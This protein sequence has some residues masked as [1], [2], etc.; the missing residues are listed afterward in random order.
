[1][2]TT[3]RVFTNEDDAL[4]FWTIAGPIP[5]CRGFAIERKIT[6]SGQTK[7]LRDF[8]P[9]RTGFAGQPLPPD[10]HG[11]GVSRPS[12]EWPFQRFSWID[13]DAN[14]GDTVS[15][16][17]VPI[18]RNAQGALESVEIEATQFSA[19]A[20]LGQATGSKY[21][22]F[23]NRGFVMSQFMAR[24]L[25]EHKLT[26]KQ[27]KAQI[28]R[29]AGADFERRIRT[30]LSGDLRKE[31][32]DLLETAR[33]D[34]T[35]VYGA[36]FELS[37]DEL[38]TAL[39][40]LGKRAHIVLANGSVQKK[41][42]ETSEE[43]RKRDENKTARK[44]L[45]T[46][47]VDVSVKDRF[48]SPGALG[49]NK[50]LVLID[51]QGKPARVWTGST[52]W[53]PTGLCTQ[54]NNGL[55]ITDHA[56]ADIY[57][58]QWK[59]LRAA[60]SAFPDDLMDANSAAHHSGKATVW[61][62]RSRKK[63]DLAAL[64]AE[65]ARAKH[66]ILFLMFMPGAT[67]ILGDVMARAGEPGLYV[68]GVVSELPHGR[69]DES[70][71]EVHLVTGKASTQMHLDIIEPEGVKRP[72]A[73]FAAEVTRTQFLS[74]VGHAIIH[75]KVLV[76]D[77]F[78]ADPVVVTGSHNFSVSA[79]GKND[80]NFVIIRGDKPL[81]QAYAVN[82]EGA[83]QH[84]RWRAFLA[85]TNIPFNGLR[86]DDAWQAPKLKSAAKELDFWGLGAFV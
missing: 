20:V 4:L 52:N 63:V 48:L 17:V 47:R 53:A 29:P 41:K 12:T 73:N 68:R 9:N 36:L 22:A 64:S 80:E 78:G 38:I 61:F 3:L 23:F 19:P 15:Y 83:Y 44:R 30:F 32:L 86:D 21:R 27:F 72:M 1:M 49:H 7:E 51:K 11:S 28:A 37:D 67:G 70:E 66:G 82:V 84:Y 25:A 69:S 81:A 56:I 34:K 42:N 79:S 14:T 6:R 35:D 24:F 76:I 43:A 2:P 71:A 74:Q 75:S 10:P 77:P 54:V 65:V 57:L 16:R 8:L 33:A 31:L 18:V 55:L 62:S 26:L 60:G 46:A 13:H 85:E 45:V 40:Q 50:F 59:R 58:A 5:G 39:E